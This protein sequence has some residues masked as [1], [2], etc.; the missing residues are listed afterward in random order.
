MVNIQE[1]CFKNLHQAMLCI[2]IKKANSR[3]FNDL[4]FR[5]NLIPAWLFTTRSSSAIIYHCDLTKEPLQPHIFREVT[6]KGFNPSDYQ[7]TQVNTV[8]WFL[9]RSSSS[10]FFINFVYNRR[11]FFLLSSLMNK[12]Q[13]SFNMSGLNVLTVRVNNQERSQQKCVELE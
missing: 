13:C 4:L 6:V 5:L 12:D 10:S 3:G 2:T 8:I 11:I 1:K 9:H 7:T